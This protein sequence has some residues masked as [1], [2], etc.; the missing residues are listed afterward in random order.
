MNGR[1][2]F[3]E[4]TRVGEAV[5]QFQLHWLNQCKARATALVGPRL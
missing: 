3:G 4:A 5:P 1:Q 2:R